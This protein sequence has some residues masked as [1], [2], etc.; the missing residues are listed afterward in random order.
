VSRCREEELWQVNG[1]T[2]THVPGREA[3]WER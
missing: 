1:L 3:R 2:P